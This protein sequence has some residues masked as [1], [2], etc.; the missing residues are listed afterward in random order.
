LF[1]RFGIVRREAGIFANNPASMRVLE[2][3]GFVRETV[4]RNVITKNGVMMDEVVYVYM[5]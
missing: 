1:E 4:L 3:C 5:R 2:R